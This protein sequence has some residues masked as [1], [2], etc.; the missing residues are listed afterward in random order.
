MRPLRHTRAEW[1]IIAF[2]LGGHPAC[3]FCSSR[4]VRPKYICVDRCAAP[5]HSGCAQPSRTRHGPIWACNLRQNTLL[6]MLATS[7]RAEPAGSGASQQPCR[8]VYER[9]HLPAEHVVCLLVR[10]VRWFARFLEISSPILVNGHGPGECR[11]WA[12]PQV[13]AWSMRYILSTI[14]IKERERKA[15]PARPLRTCANTSHAGLRGTRYRRMTL[16][17]WCTS[18]PFEKLVWFAWHAGGRPLKNCGQ[19]GEV[20]QHI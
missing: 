3:F 19:E 12:P 14:H 9:H 20:L 6:L 4:T 13:F 16:S 10:L 5:A 11:P 17:G 2:K 8:L 15:A 18:F 7:S 1:P